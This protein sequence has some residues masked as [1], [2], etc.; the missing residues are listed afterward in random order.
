MNTTFI[1]LLVLV[2]TS[3]GVFIATKFFGTFKDED[4]NG[5]PDKLEEKVEE[6]VTEVK[7]RA[8]KVVKE[9]KDVTKAVKQVAKQSKD[10]VKA[11]TSKTPTRRGRK[12]KQ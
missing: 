8:K 1:I 7:K 11:A 3:V 4:K 6:V 12:P 9:T 2:L 10:V 5:V